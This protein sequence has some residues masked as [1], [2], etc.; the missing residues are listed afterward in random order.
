[1]GFRGWAARAFVALLGVMSLT[2]AGLGQSVHDT[3]PTSLQTVFVFGGRY[4]SEY[5][6]NGL[7]PFKP[8]YENNYFVGAGYQRFLPGD[9]HQWRLGLEVGLAARFGDTTSAEMWAGGVARFDGIVLGN[10]RISPAITLG[11]SAESG[12]VG[13]ETVHAQE[14]P[15]GGDPAL[16]F[17]MGPEINLS[18]ADN[19][20]LEVF[21]RIQH[22]SGAWNTLGNMR[23]GANATA[24]GMR[25]KF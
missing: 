13:V 21:W 16:L 1:M 23:D 7:N 6:E 12:P 18:W 22:R 2:G 25:W 9:W 17:Y 10:V 5:I 15:G 8:A 14:V 24:V 20:D 3:D 4:Y 11:I 19:P